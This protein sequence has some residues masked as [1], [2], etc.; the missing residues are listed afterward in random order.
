SPKKIVVAEETLSSASKNKEDTNSRGCHFKSLRGNQPPCGN[1]NINEWGFCKKHTRTVQAKEAEAALLK[2]KELDKQR[3][4]QELEEELAN[5][6][7]DTGDDIA[8][9]D[10]KLIIQPNRYGRFE[11]ADTGIVFNPDTNIAIGIQGDDGKLWPLDEEA[12][13]QCV[14]NGW[15]YLISNKK[16]KDEEEEELE[17][18]QE[19]EEDS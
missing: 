8:S 5:L 16:V 1:T 6:T 17:D 10:E 9:D 2:A 18:D 7:D 12:I 11:H 14:E 4:L 19:Y 15:L 13:R 3:Q